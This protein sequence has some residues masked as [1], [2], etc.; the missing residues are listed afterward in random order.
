MNST[1][2]T[3]ILLLFDMHYGGE[4]RRCLTVL[5]EPSLCAT[6][7]SRSFREFSH[8]KLVV[9]SVFI[10]AKRVVR[11]VASLNL[12]FCMSARL[13]K[14]YIHSCPDDPASSL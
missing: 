3:I 10:R 5:D 8:L 9:T 2:L 14:C 1:W 11:F 6:M 12:R 13:F 4:L 7:D